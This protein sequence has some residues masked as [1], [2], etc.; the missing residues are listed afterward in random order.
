[1]TCREGHNSVVT[2]I[3]WF[4]TRDPTTKRDD[5]ALVK[6]TFHDLKRKYAQEG[7]PSSRGGTRQR[8]SQ[9]TPKADPAEVVE[10][11]E[12]K[13]AIVRHDPR[14]KDRLRPSWQSKLDAAISAARAGDGPD[15][16]TFRAWRELEGEVRAA[17]EEQESLRVQTLPTPEEYREA[18]ARARE[19]R[20]QLDRLVA[21]RGRR[22]FDGPTRAEVA[23]LRDE[24]AS[25]DTLISR[26][27]GDAGDIN[28]EVLREIHLEAISS[29]RTAS[30]REREQA[31]ARA[32]QAQANYVEALATHPALRHLAVVAPTAHESDD[33]WSNLQAT[34]LAGRGDQWQALEFLAQRNDR[35]LAQ[36][37][38]ISPLEV[39]HRMGVRRSRRERVAARESTR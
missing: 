33:P 20:R 23:A 28:V 11:L 19:L 3:A 26:G 9:R 12:D 2:S 1:M 16:A 38:Q 10:F 30:D 22:Q 8:V 18:V 29:L 14:I 17:K 25:N 13:K 15:A 5:E 39:R 32:R 35:A 7:A 24:I 36:A 31:H 37:G 4:L 6:K 21:E 34:E 27:G